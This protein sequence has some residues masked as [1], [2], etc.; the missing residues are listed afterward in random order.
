MSIFT[1]ALKYAVLSVAVFTVFFMG[2]AYLTSLFLDTSAVA[3]VNPEEEETITDEG[4]RT[5]ILVLGVDARPADDHSRSDTMIL[6]SIDPK[7]RKVALVS[8][9][10]DTKIKINGESNKICTANY[11]G[12]P[13]LAVAKVEELMNIKIDNY[14]EVDFNGFSHIIDTLGG[15]TLNVEQRMYKPT[16]GID[17][18]PG[19]QRLDGKDALAY[20]RYRDYVMGDIDRATKQQNFLKALAGEILQAKNIVK[21][22]KL[23]NQLNDYMVTDLKISDM[24]RLASWAPRFNEE[25]IITQTLPGYFYDEKDNLGTLLN[26]YWVADSKQARTLLDDLFAGKAVTALVNM[27]AEATTKIVKYYNI[28]SNTVADKGTGSAEPDSD[29]SAKNTE[30]GKSSAD[31]DD[32]SSPKTDVKQKKSTPKDTDNN[33]KEKTKQ[34]PE[35]STEKSRNTNND[36]E[37]T[38]DIKV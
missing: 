11:Y 4:E 17:L 12:G 14:V 3:K 33:K 1:K 35:R 20:V 27:P 24:L 37:R 26:S 15:V 32:K 29:K 30:D 8:V 13:E 36:T 34:S 18:Q 31:R 21:L 5:N 9:P 23:A 7:L 22:P 10:R 2:G 25:S 28:P 38:N 6:A 16:E 19:V